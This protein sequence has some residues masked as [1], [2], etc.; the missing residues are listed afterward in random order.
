M[1]DKLSRKCK[2]RVIRFLQNNSPKL[3]KIALIQSLL[4]LGTAVMISLC[5]KYESRKHYTTRRQGYCA[6]NTFISKKYRNVHTHVRYLGIV[7]SD[8]PCID[9]DQLVDTYIITNSQ[10]IC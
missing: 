4:R 9:Q 2:C 1:K 8:P 7:I 5:K 3:K 10:Q 6:C